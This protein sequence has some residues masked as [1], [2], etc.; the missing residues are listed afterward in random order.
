MQRFLN[1][2]IALLALALLVMALRSFLA[3]MRQG[4]EPVP[5]A[6]GVRQASRPVV[7]RERPVRVDDQTAH[8]PM[9][10]LTITY[11][12]PIAADAMPSVATDPVH[13]VRTSWNDRRTVLT[14]VPTDPWTPGESYAVAVGPLV[15]ARGVRVAA[16]RFALGVPSL[17]AVATIAPADGATDVVLDIEDSIMVTF[18]SPPGEDFDIDLRLSGDVPLTVTP[19]VADGAPGTTLQALPTVPLTAGMRYELTVRTR[20]KGEDDNA[21]RTIGT[22]AFTLR[23]PAPDE[24]S[25]DFPERLRQALHYTPARILQ[26]R[27]IDINKATQ[28]LTIFEDGRA[29]DAY[30]I[31][32]GRP[33]M[34][35]PSGTWHVIN[36]YPRP[37]SKMYGL[38]MPY[39][40]AITPYGHGIHELPEWPNGYKEG[41]RN[42]GHAV[43]HGCVRLGVGPAQRVYEWA[44]VG[45]PVVVH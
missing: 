26:G 38:Y 45:T 40:M 41:A 16:A 39:W 33:G 7:A 32:S 9:H 42:L 28:V 29:L 3:D 4:A 17:P 21:W 19:A 44:S 30:M 43:S 13:P 5:V 20:W 27:Y 8:T 25:T 36:K 14:I 2:L 23:P 22:S 31:S 35:T 6:T 18:A 1:I 37:W 34:D 24:W 12:T 11:D 15:S 10:A